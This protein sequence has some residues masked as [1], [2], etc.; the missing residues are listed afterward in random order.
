MCVCMCMFYVTLQTS[1]A[2]YFPGTSMSIF[3]LFYFFKL[4]EKLYPT[5]PYLETLPKG[6]P[7]AVVPLKCC[8]PL[9]TDTHKQNLWIKKKRKKVMIMMKLR[10]KQEMSDILCLLGLHQGLGKMCKILKLEHLPNRCNNTF[11]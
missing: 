4:F 2:V 3:I 1:T 5:F 7:S 8:Y 6:D 9:N 11:D 10:K